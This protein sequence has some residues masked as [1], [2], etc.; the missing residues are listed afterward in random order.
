MKILISPYWKY[1]NDRLHNKKED[2]K[3]RHI[4]QGLY[5]LKACAHSTLSVRPFNPKR[6]HVSGKMCA[7]FLCGTKKDNIE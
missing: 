5:I 4:K 3:Y 2:Y 1:K 7:R 6:A